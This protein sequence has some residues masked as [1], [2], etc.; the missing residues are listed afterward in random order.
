MA[1]PTRNGG[2]APE[3][4]EELKNE[5][6]LLVKAG[7]KSV[8]NRYRTIARVPPEFNNNARNFEK[9]CIEQYKLHFKTDCIRH[10]LTGTSDNFVMSFYARCFCDYPFMKQHR[11][12]LTIDQYSAFKKVG[13]TSW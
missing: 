10:S 9:W 3:V 7:Y 6:L 11:I 1:K 12:I 13:G 4:T 5:M 2:W 8:S